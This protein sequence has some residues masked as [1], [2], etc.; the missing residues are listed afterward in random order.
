MDSTSV[1][2]R[3]KKLL[4][5]DY[6]E[7]NFGDACPLKVYGHSLDQARVIDLEDIMSDSKSK[8]ASTPLPRTT[9]MP[10]RTPQLTVYGD[11]KKLTRGGGGTRKDGGGQ[12]APNTKA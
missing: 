1:T 10:Y 7:L 11:V 3:E 5:L 12:T 8:P 6:F 2:N 9:K 4:L